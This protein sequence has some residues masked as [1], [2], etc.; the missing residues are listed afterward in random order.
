MK[1]KRMTLENFRGYKSPVSVAFDNM[2]AFIGK[3]DAGKSTILEALDIFFN[4]GKG[5]IKLDKKDINIDNQGT[6]HNEI[7][8]S[9][10]FSDLPEKIIIDET[11]ET[12][13]SKEY[14][15]NKYGEL[16]IIKLLKPTDGKP[17]VK[18]FI[19]ANHPAN[20]NC[21]DLLLKKNK[22][23]AKIITE[24]GIECNK[25]KNAE[26]RAAIWKYYHDDLQLEE[27]EIDV[28]T[29]DSD[30]KSVWEKLQTYLPYYSLF[31]SDRKNT[32]SDDEVQD[33]LKEAVKQ[34]LSSEELREQ[35]R[36]I[37]ERVKRKL[38]EV[39]DLTLEKIKEINPEIANTLHP[40]IP[41]PESLKWGDV[42][43]GL[44][45]YGDD[46][47]IN[48]RG[49]GVKRL[50]LLN[51]FRAQAEKKKDEK[52]SPSIIYAIEEPETSQ[53]VEHQNMLIDALNSLAEHD[54]IQVILTTHSANIVK[55][56]GYKDLRL[57][58]HSGT[59]YES[60]I[61]MVS[62]YTLPYTSL[63]EVNYMVFGE[64]TEEFHNELYGFLQK[65]A[66]DGAGN[67]DHE[68]EFD[69]WLLRKGCSKSK[70][71]I[72]VK[73]KTPLPPYKVTLQTFIRNSIHHPENRENTRYT[74]EEL[75]NSII[76]MM[77]IATTLSN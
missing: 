36:N 2:T 20:P 40:N 71:W 24:L 33:P 17:T 53:H 8:I 48:K 73:N 75:K 49:S 46:I 23:L 6:D 37:A 64:V 50:I 59:S 45:I 14:L 43:K 56:L 39:S 1:L 25:V 72:R 70:S 62:S 18:T 60:S 65:K 69:D 32:D 11:N 51:F 7:R 22:E 58:M 38:Q 9:L 12:E 13:L 10:S 76:E 41:S 31:Q 52:K 61:K 28:S 44:S 16:E 68:K 15:L 47:P 19:R 67:C 30:I 54:D 63:N 55:K 66:S 3:N 29:K 21:K 42:F 34:I 57:T 26:M 35:L 27:Y 77:E 74:S 4:D 5:L